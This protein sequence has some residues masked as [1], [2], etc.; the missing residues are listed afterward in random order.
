MA[1]KTGKIRQKDHGLERKV[2]DKMFMMKKW[3]IF[4]G[5][6]RIQRKST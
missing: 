5:K 1:F 3:E 6:V 2:H 4:S